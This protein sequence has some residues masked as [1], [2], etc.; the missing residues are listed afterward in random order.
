MRLCLTALILIMPWVLSAQQ[1]EQSATYVSPLDQALDL[2]RIT[3][4][5]VSDNVNGIY[6]RPIENKLIE[7]LQKSHQWDYVESK[8]A[9]PILSPM[10]LES[11]SKQVQQL[12]L[13]AGADTLVAVKAT[14]GQDGMTLVL[15]IFLTYDGLLFAQ[16]ELRKHPNTNV[17]DI[18]VQAVELLKK[19]L[20]KVPF[21]GQVLSREGNRVTVNIGSIDGVKKDQLVSAAQIIK[22]NRH[23]KFNFVVSAEKEILGKIKLEK[24]DETLS[25]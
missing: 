11:D 6:A 9:G 25:F 14:K 2:R 22:L 1:I 3:I 18:Q 12:G 4:L 17:S 10:E 13:S 19:A 24:V 20:G 23:P 16:E 21:Q 8:V 15:D 5:P 7:A